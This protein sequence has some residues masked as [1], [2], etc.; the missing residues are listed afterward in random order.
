MNE[1]A[2]EIRKEI[3]STRLQLRSNEISDNERRRLVE[4]EKLL[5]QDLYRA[6]I[7]EV[8]GGMERRKDDKHKRK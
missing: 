3:A 7:E 6:R 5:Q 1:E 8:F 4:K 2:K